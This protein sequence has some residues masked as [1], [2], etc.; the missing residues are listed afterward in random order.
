MRPY[1][2]FVV[3]TPF[4]DLLFIG[5]AT[6]VL[7]FRVTP[8]NE[9]ALRAYA[10]KSKSFLNWRENAFMKLLQEQPRRAHSIARGAW[11]EAGQ[12][13]IGSRKMMNQVE[14]QSR[15]SLSNVVNIK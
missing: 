12:P 5:Y 6:E 2:W 15:Q 7:I 8:E 3:S 9:N 4:Y 10:K 14:K 13:I 11:M 1:F